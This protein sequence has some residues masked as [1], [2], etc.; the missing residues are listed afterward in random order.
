MQETRVQSLTWEDPTCCRTAK[1]VR[2]NY[3]AWALEPGCCLVAQ[4]CLTLCD[5]TDCSTPG[6]SLLHHFPK[7]IQTHAHWVGD[8]IQPSHPLLSPSPAFNLSQHQDLFQWVNSLHQVTKVLGPQPQHQSLQWIFRA[9]F[10]Y[11][12]LVWSPA[13]QGTLKSLLQHH[14]SKASILWHSAFF[15]FQHSHPY[16]TSGKTIALTIWTFVGNVSDF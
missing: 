14:S 4:L 2:H 9:D 15:M 5:P 7:L 12:G 16:M 3:W 6:F 8:T 1:P 13:V 10:L 11:D